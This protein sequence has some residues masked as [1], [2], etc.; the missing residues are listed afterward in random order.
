MT[1]QPRN[2]LTLSNDI[3]PTI[4]GSLESVSSRV[5]SLQPTEDIPDTISDSLFLQ[6]PSIDLQESLLILVNLHLVK[7]QIKSMLNLRYHPYNKRCYLDSVITA[8]FKK[9]GYVSVRFL[10]FS[11]SAV[12]VFLQ[13]CTIPLNG[14]HL[15]H[16]TSINS[17]FGVQPRSV[18]LYIEFEFNC[19]PLFKMDLI[20]GFNSICTHVD[21][22]GCIVKHLDIEDR[23]NP[24]EWFSFTEYFSNLQLLLDSSSEF[25]LPHL[26]SLAF[27][28][29]S[30]S[31]TEKFNLLCKTLMTN[32]TLLELDIEFYRLNESEAIILAEVIS[33]NNTLKK[34]S[35]EGFTF[36][37]EAY[38]LGNAISKNS[39]IE[40]LRISGWNLSFNLFDSY[41]LNKIEI[42]EGCFH[43]G[44][45]VQKP[46]SNLTIRELIFNNFGIGGE[47]LAETVNCC[48]GLR[49]LVIYCREASKYSPIPLFEL[50][51]ANTSIL[52]LQVV[53][54][55]SRKPL[56]DEE[57]QSL[58]KMLENNVTL[59]VLNLEL[60]VTSTQFLNIADRLK[61]NSSLSETK[62]KLY[63]LDLNC[64]MV[65]FETF[66]VNKLNCSL[67]SS[68]H[69]IDVDNG[70]FCFSPVCRANYTISYEEISSLGSFLECFSIKK[71]TLKRC[72]F[73]KESIT[74]L[75]DLIRSNTSLT[76]VDFGDFEF[77]EL[78]Q[79]GTYQRIDNFDY[80]GHHSHLIDAIQCNS[81]LT[82]VTLSN[83]NMSSMHFRLKHVSK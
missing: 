62:L 47:L 20:L 63:A 15:H 52:E 35:L 59:L 7:R 27:V 49:K 53:Y 72:R 37:S 65:M 80:Y 36:S 14:Q 77:V 46:A 12:K 54:N 44:Q 10:E 69:F 25:F 4:D 9:V 43:S 50:L 23:D 1:E 26:R 75:C 13:S 32:T 76:S 66:A 34:I 11:I 22:K 73:T 16:L 30:R 6:R 40:S 17:L 51:E 57:V 33:S 81:R 56:A 3:L 71:L 28:A 83:L 8:F 61:M 2:F 48:T 82:K 42:Y 55:Q 79:N 74:A 67:D 31:G 39:L 64:L 29:S 19:Q 38:L 21:S 24:N 18:S 58:G 60:S 78:T 5:S 41:S 70:V 45:L 68:T